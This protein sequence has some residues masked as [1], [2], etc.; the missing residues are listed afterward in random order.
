MA[1]SRE[2]ASAASLD[3]VTPPPAAPDAADRAAAADPA[4]EHAVQDLLDVLDL[5]ELGEARI[6]IEG[7]PGDDETDLGESTPT[8][9]VG[10][11][12]PQAHGRVFGGQVLA[13]SLVAAARTVDAVDGIPRPIHSLHAYFVRGG[14]DQHPIRFVVERVHDGRSFSTRRVLA[15]QYGRPILTMSASFQEPADGMDHQDPMPPAPDPEDVPTLAEA[16]GRDLDPDVAQF[17]AA[18]RPIEL[19]HVQGNI[20]VKPARQRAPRESVWLRARS[21]LP[22]DPI[23]HAAVLAFASDYPLLE[24]VLRRHGIAWRDPRLRPASLDHAMWF[25]R[26]PKADDWVL[27]TLISPSASG[28]R[29]LGAGR[30]FSAD[31]VLMASVAQEGMVRLKDVPP[32]GPEAGR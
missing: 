13:Q 29:G 12:I 17:F 15:V 19:R 1:A 23:I 2:W 25:H 8:V 10:R 5:R 3:D 14:D 16:L 26:T 9:F 24:P 32:P 22:D 6:V 27:Y 30:M 28:G 21:P 20:Y 18:R 4:A 31:G 7:A 11:S